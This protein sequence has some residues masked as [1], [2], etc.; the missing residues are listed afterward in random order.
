M[1]HTKAHVVSRHILSAWVVFALIIL[2]VNVTDNAHWLGQPWWVSVHTV[3]LGLIGTSI[4][5]WSWHFAAALLRFGDRGDAGQTTR[6]ICFTVGAVVLMGAMF[7][8]AFRFA[9]LGGVVILGAVCWH[10][11]ALA[12]A[13]LKA[14]FRSKFAVLAAYYIFACFFL[15]VG[16]GL[17]F[18]AV[19]DMLG[20]PPSRV[21]AWREAA[22][23][24]H[25]LVNVTGFIGLTLL[26]TLVTLGP[27]I[28]RTRMDPSAA[29]SAKLALP[30]LVMCI[31]G[32]GV[33]ALF[34][35]PEAMCLAVGLYSLCALLVLV[36]VFKVGWGKRPGDFAALSLVCGLA[37]VVAGFV[38][39]AVGTVLAL[40]AGGLR[41]LM[42]TPLTI[43]LMGVV[44]IVL[45][46]MSYLFPVL[47]GGGPRC[48]KTALRYINSYR[49][50]RLFILN[51]SGVAALLLPAGGSA[52]GWALAGLALLW[53][54]VVLIHASVRQALL[55][56]NHAAA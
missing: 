41:P 5:T 56:R 27:T 30:L 43:V 22:T 29:Q 51:A 35:S 12:V 7:T 37:W 20:S 28:F 13:F 26:G 2:V 16:I 18:F 39:I 6:L 38:A 53:S 54:F 48:V 52:L 42:Q 49:E 40:R 55:R 44:Q 8:H 33:A 25:A 23:S 32:V 3:T 19:W 15:I 21:S 50:V 46:A 1:R 9:L 14:P 31:F 36:P 17:A 11:A 10:A 24:A 45:A 47:I 34:Q 4:L